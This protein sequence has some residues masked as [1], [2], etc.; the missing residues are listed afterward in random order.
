MAKEKY[1][2]AL[3]GAF[4]QFITP[5]EQPKAPEI[6]P[7]IT[8]QRPRG[9]NSISPEEREKRKERAKHNAQY[10]STAPAM[11][12]AARDAENPR[13]RRVQLL[14]RP[15]IHAELLAIAHAQ[16]RSLNNL[17]EEVLTDYINGERNR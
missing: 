10:I 8:E 14:F 12:K 15:N 6:T 2:N 3:T 5:T 9:K 16:G 11:Y 1:K 17:I 4:N 13:G 7:P